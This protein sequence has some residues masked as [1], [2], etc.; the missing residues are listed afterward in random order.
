MVYINRKIQ[1]QIERLLATG[2]SLLLLGPRQT[3]KTTLIQSLNVDWY[4]SFLEPRTRQ[5]Y[6]RNPSVF[7]DEVAAIVERLRGEKS[8]NQ[9]SMRARETDGASS[10]KRPLVVIDEVQKIPVMMN[11]VQHLIDTQQAQLILTGSSARKLRRAPDVNFLPGRLIPLHMTPLCI[12]EYLDYLPQQNSDNNLVSLLLFGS[13]PE[14]FLTQETELKQILLSAYVTT[15]LE[16]E[17]RSEALVRDLAPFAHFLE[18]SAGEAG[19]P[20]NQNKL[21]QRIGVAQTTIT[22]Y[23]QILEDCLIC[24]RVSPLLD[25]KTRHRLS[26]SDKILFF[27]LGVRRVAAGE[28]L[29]PPEKHFGHLFEQ[30]VGLECLRLLHTCANSAK[31]CYWRD[32]NGPEVDW[33]LVFPDCYIPIE[34]KWTD[35]PKKSDARHLELFIAEHEKA[36]QGFVVCRTPRPMQLTDN[37]QAIPWQMIPILFQ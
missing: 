25:G 2:K 27:D 22:N 6:E 28:G 17:V 31:L 13:L 12:N 35:A 33:V 15:Y 16:E 8:V 26:K 5:R 32:L 37:V 11:V 34:V 19:H 21:S 18:L 36:K 30:F 1:A 7:A 29:D 9:Y 23:Y 14:I 10:F 24:T 3:G 20:I 4:V